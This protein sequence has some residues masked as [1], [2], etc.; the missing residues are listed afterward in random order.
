MRGSTCGP[1]PARPDAGPAPAR[2]PQRGDLALG[3][4]GGADAP[5]RPP[6]PGPG[7]T[8]IAIV[9]AGLTG[10]CAAYA[11]RRLAPDRSVTVLEAEHVGFGASGRNGGWLSHLVAGDRARYAAGPGGL[12]GAVRMQAA[13]LAGIDE[14]LDLCA[15]EGIEA[16]QHRGGH[17]AVATTPAGLHR[18]RAAQQ[19]DLRYGL[20]RE[21]S[22]LLG[23]R[24][25]RDRIDAHG[26]LGGLWH[27]M[28]V[29]INPAKLVTGLAAAVQ[30]H[31]AVIHE[32]TRVHRV[33]PGLAADRPR[34]AARRHGAGLH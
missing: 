33:E 32:R 25:T 6:L 14:V 1:S 5:T 24:A 20:A 4:D 22:Q 15:R 21:Q 18:L 7:S 26:A 12:D 31:G 34:R 10:L 9:G 3:A 27:P 19:A 8:D 29:R 23:A 2:L 17:L 13:V 28:V 11:L 16:E 30:R